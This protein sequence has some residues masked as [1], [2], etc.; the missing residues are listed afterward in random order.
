MKKTSEGKKINKYYLMT[1]ALAVVV[2]L[3]GIVA[4]R[5]YAFRL[6]DS[7]NEHTYD[8]YY[9]MI[10]DDPKS[11]F[12]QEVY[13]G[14]QERALEDNVFVELLGDNL[15]RSYST[16]ELMDIAIAS[17]PDGIMVY[18]DESE[19]MR[20]RIN[21][22][23]SVGIP[24]VTLYNDN[25]LSN[26]CSFIGVSGYNIGREYGK[27]IKQIAL[28]RKRNGIE[29]DVVDIT[30][31]TDINKEDSLYTLILSGLQETLES[32]S[33]LDASFS[34]S[35]ANVD[36]T[37]AFSAEESIRDIFAQDEV[38]DI[39]V[40]LN[41]QNTTC[42]YQAVVDFNM[43]KDVNILGYYDSTTILNAIYHSAVY[44]TVSVDTY[45]MGKFCTE[46][47]IEYNE[48]GNTS[49]YF[50][51]EVTIIDGTNVV[52]HLKKKEENNE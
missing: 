27:L 38:P 45:N 47:L 52:F 7:K 42:A 16:I 39:L 9:V 31:L 12:W 22:A 33:N 17:H 43:V 40:C 5:F 35:F 51:T 1:I 20:E 4:F 11:S 25:T 49:Q 15:S 29:D 13:K 46:A 10:T 50:T 6:S 24:V 48:M 18:A 8:S 19:E 21:E 26:R 30:V 41:E 3:I 28:K 32:K 14:A 37:N 34:I 44:A 23:V 36:N 2:L